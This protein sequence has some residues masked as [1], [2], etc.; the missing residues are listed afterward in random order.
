MWS[1]VQR[2]PAVVSAVVWL[3]LL[4]ATTTVLDLQGDGR[5]GWASAL[6]VAYVLY[7]GGASWYFRRRGL[8]PGTPAERAAALLF[9]LAVSPWLAATGLA[10]L[11]AAPWTVWAALLVSGLLLG[12]WAV[13]PRP[14]T[15]A[16]P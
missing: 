2:R 1:F 5:S 13:R 8:P 12:W 15:V 14:T 10:F 16:T 4:G 9:A 11:G 3:L 6:N 7:A